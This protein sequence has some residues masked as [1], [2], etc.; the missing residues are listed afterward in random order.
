LR[1]GEEWFSQ[2]RSLNIEKCIKGTSSWGRMFKRQSL[3]K[4]TPCLMLFSA[5]FVHFKGLENPREKIVW[6]RIQKKQMILK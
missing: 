3:K 1:K 5:Y 2:S 4:S 6:G